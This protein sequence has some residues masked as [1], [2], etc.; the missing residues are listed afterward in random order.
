MKV[1]IVRSSTHDAGA[2]PCIDG[3]GV[4][5]CEEK[6]PSSIRHQPGIEKKRTSPHHSFESG[7]F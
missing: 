2:A 7:Y 4:C 5:A 3:E 6:R 1:L